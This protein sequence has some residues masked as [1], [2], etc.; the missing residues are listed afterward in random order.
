MAKTNAD[1]TVKQK[2]RGGLFQLLIVLAAIAYFT[3]RLEVKG[4]HISL[5]LDKN[6]KDYLFYIKR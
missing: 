4:D 1:G 3:G 2:K 5:K 6:S